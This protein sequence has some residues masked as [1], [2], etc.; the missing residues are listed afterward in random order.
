MKV[1]V[2][3]G[4]TEGQTRKIAEFAADKL[5]VMGDEVTLMDASTVE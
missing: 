4:T 2:L 1:V 3:Y 5:R